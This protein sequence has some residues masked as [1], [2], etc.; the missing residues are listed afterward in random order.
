WQT[1]IGLDIR[2]QKMWPMFRHSFSHFHL[3]ITPIPARTTGNCERVMGEPEKSRTHSRVRAGER[4]TKDGRAGVSK[5]HRAAPRTASIAIENNET[6]WY[7]VTRP[8][9]RGLAAPVR[10]L[11]Q[12]LLRDS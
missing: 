1:H 7:N 3:D 9:A 2:P 12:Q 5:K 10:K 11:L 8:D 4:P 6:V